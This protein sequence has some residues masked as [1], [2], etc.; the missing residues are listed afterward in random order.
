ME[1]VNV[2]VDL[3]NEV[4][5][6]EGN[7]LFLDS[8]LMSA[9]AAKFPDDSGRLALAL[10]YIVIGDND[11]YKESKISEF[12]SQRELLGNEYRGNIEIETLNDEMNLSCV[13]LIGYMKINITA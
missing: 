4:L 13:N 8:R 10:T 3:E 2:Q 6:V 7:D 12:L 11:F 5:N 1:K 9:E